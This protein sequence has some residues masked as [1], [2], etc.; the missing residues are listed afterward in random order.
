MA[1][2]IAAVE[3]HAHAAT[4]VPR[5]EAAKDNFAKSAG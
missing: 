3:I 1:R 2:S 4:T 5:A